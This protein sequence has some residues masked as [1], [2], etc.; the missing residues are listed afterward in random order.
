MEEP[1]KRLT[2]LWL[3]LF[4]IA[5]NVY[6]SD[7]IILNGAG[8]TFPFPLYQKWIDVF[9]NQSETRITY[10][11]VGSGSGIRKIKNMEI[12][13]G[14]SDA[15]L[16]DDELSS[17]P[18]QILHVPTC[19]GAV[20]VIYHLPGDPHLKFT[21]E[22]LADLFSNKIKS[23][24]DPRIQSVNEKTSLPDMPV[25]IIHRAE[26]S[27]TTYLF[28]KYL[29]S[30]SPPW[31]SAI[32][33]GKSVNWPEGIGVEGNPGVAEL[34]KKISGSVGYVELTYAQTHHLSMAS[35][36]NAAGNF[37]TPTIQSVSNAARLDLP[38]DTRMLLLNTKTTQGYPISGFTYLL[39]Y[40]EQDYQ[41]RSLEKARAL[42][43]LLNWMIHQGQ[44]YT[45][46]LHYAPLP[47]KAVVKAEKIIESITYDH[48]PIQ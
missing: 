24:A 46:D 43:Q 48:K 42:K 16:S 40:R 31:N 6:S 29:S 20:V 28:T 13:F 18:A 1:M 34:V 35:I 2:R 12:D 5:L 47:D 15:F 27:G 38:D 32:G 45:Q 21:P 9:Q 39:V 30:I 11:G 7:I 44:E 14:G 8:A 22:L 37:I 3:I 23:W 33:A 19:V 4:C 26:S 41:S 25:T 36:K 17:M 10:Q